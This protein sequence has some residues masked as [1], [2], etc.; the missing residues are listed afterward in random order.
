ME[1]GGVG[2]DLVG[3]SPAGFQATVCVCVCRKRHQYSSRGISGSSV[4]PPS[5]QCVADGFIVKVAWQS[6]GHI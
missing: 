2:G 1:T 4:E 6:I 5:A 3:S